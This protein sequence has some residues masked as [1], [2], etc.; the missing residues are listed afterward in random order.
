M[1]VSR[2]SLLAL[3]PLAWA[4][5]AGVALAATQS[6][7][8]PLTGA[9]QVPPVDTQGTGTAHLTYNPATREVTWSITF[10]NLSSPATMAHF[11]NGAQGANGPVVIWLSTKGKAPSSPI[12]GKATLTADQAQQF[13]AGQWYVN[14]HSKDHPAGELRGQVTP[15]AS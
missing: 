5:S 1:S 7:N 2:R 10:S 15:P 4:G 11:H 8:V 3:V 12:R 14:V 9:Q 13:T 6:F